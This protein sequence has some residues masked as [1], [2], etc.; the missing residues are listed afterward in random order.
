MLNSDNKFQRYSIWKVKKSWRRH[1]VFEQKM[2][3]CLSFVLAM[4]NYDS[5]S[6]SWVSAFCRHPKCWILITNSR[7]IPLERSKNHDD[8]TISLNKKW[9]C[10]S[11]LCLPWKTM[12]PSASLE[13]QL[14]W[15]FRD[16]VNLSASLYFLDLKSGITLEFVFR[17]QHLG[18]L[19]KADTQ[20]KLM[21]S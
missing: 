5:I 4:K 3:L 11:P 8:D 9:F 2:I 1:Y 20:E 19:Q 17:I 21:E 18:C 6:F 12:T 15:H 16:S 7:D 13:C 10:A 14:H